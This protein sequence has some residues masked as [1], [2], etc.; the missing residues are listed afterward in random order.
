MTSVFFTLPISKFYLIAFTSSTLFLCPVCICWMG[1]DRGRPVGAGKAY[2]WGQVMP[3]N[4]LCSTILPVFNILGLWCF[5]WHKRNCSQWQWMKHWGLVL[6]SFS[7][8]FIFE[9]VVNNNRSMFFFLLCKESPI[10]P[11][12][13]HAQC[14]SS[15]TIGDEHTSSSLESIIKVIISAVIIIG[16]FLFRAE[17]IYEGRMPMSKYMQ[18]RYLSQK[19]IFLLSR[20]TRG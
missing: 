12:V 18:E 20:T 1:V 19:C 8:L 17:T 9:L 13:L 11:F 4:V 15:K 5:Q 16:L 6:I 3:N 2:G 14:F 10:K 7:L